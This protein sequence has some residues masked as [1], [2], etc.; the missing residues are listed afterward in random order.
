MRNVKVKVGNLAGRNHRLVSLSL[1]FCSRTK[2]I[3]QINTLLKPSSNVDSNLLPPTEVVPVFSYP[4][5]YDVL[6]IS[7]ANCFWL[8]TK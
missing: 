7:Y 3:L 8:H 4:S 1:L 2:L 5:D 6:S